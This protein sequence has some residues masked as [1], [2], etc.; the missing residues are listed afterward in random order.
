MMAINGSRMTTRTYRLVREQLI[1][2]LAEAAELEHNLLCCYLYAAFS[3]KRRGDPGLSANE[4]AAVERWRSIIVGVAVQEMGH[5][6]SVNNLLVSIGGDPHFGRP[7]FPVPA[8]YHPAGFDIRL[9]PLSE[10]TLAQFIGFERPEAHAESTDTAGPGRASPERSW[11]TPVGTPYAT[12]GEFYGD[13]QAG[14]RELAKRHGASAFIQDDRQ[15]NGQDIG[16]ADVAVI[17]NL[18]DAL[19]ALESI[20][21]QGEG[22]AEAAAECH[23]DRFCAIRDEWRSLLAVNASFLPAHTAARDPVMRKPTKGGRTWITSEEALPFLDLGNAV[24]GVL[25]LLLSRLYSPGS[26]E[27]RKRLGGVAVK[28]MHALSALGSRLARLPSGDP[29]RGNAGLTFAVPRNIGGRGSL[30][31]LRERLLELAENYPED[32]TPNPLVE[33]A[34]TLG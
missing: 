7:N 2:L 8:G 34:T 1:H 22:A 23:F 10:Q 31:L 27:E 17:R 13:I 18:P 30:R 14:F 33:A 28:L 15:L 26:P 11:I 25:L 29:G 12:I 6:A 32:G 19:S 3:L 20:V 9:A 5:L 16:V 24:Y 21:E 4:V